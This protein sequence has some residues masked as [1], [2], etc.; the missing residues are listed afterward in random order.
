MPLMGRLPT[1]H[2]CLPLLG[3][4]TSAGAPYACRGVLPLGVAEVH[5]HSHT[6]GK[7]HPWYYVRLLPLLALFIPACAPLPF[8][9]PS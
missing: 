9:A 3:R 7:L 2:G 4:P 8:R 6:Y 5:L 1:S